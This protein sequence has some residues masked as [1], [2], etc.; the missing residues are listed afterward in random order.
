[1]SL[2]LFNNRGFFEDPFFDNDSLFDF[3]TPRTLGGWLNKVPLR[4]EEGQRWMTIPVN[5]SEKDNVLKIQCETPGLKKEDIN[6]KLQDDVLSI[7]FEK[8]R[9]KED[10][11]ETYHRSEMFQGRFKRTLRLPEHIDQ[12]SIQAQM[13]N[14]VLSICLNKLPQLQ[15]PQSVNIPI[16]GE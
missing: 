5:V 6:L 12:N 3:T 10:K 13:N 7:E 14:G 4:D 8:T 9:K 11:G 1:M 15:Q 2:S 16:Q